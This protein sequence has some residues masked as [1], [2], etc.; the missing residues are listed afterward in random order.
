MTTF[1]PLRTFSYRYSTLKKIPAYLTYFASSRTFRNILDHIFP[2]RY[3]HSWGGENWFLSILK[4]PC[5]CNV[6]CPCNKPAYI[7][8]CTES[9]LW[10]FQ[11]WGGILGK[12]FKLLLDT[13]FPKSGETVKDEASY[14]NTW[15][16]SR[17][18][19]S[20]WAAGFSLIVHMPPCPM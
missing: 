8:R 9:V 18:Q 6:L 19:N 13:Q 2:A 16:Q 17:V 7:N 15:F 3:H 5:Y 20:L 4:K 14:Q 12:N 1:P 11:G 10:K